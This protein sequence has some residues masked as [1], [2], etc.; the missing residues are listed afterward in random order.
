M[1]ENQ[2]FQNKNKYLDELRHL[3][4]QIPKMKNQDWLINFIHLAR[5][6]YAE[7]LGLEGEFSY[8][9]VEK[10]LERLGFSG[11]KINQIREFNDKLFN[12]QFAPSKEKTSLHSLCGELQ[13]LIEGSTEEYMS[14]NRRDEKNTDKPKKKHPIM[15][16]IHE[17][18]ERKE[19][20]L[21]L[22]IRRLIVKAY[23]Y[24]ENNNIKQAAK[25]YNEIVSLFEKTKESHSK[26][27]KEIK[28]LYEEI[29]T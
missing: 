23:G 2:A 17:L 7:N 24:L 19:Q 5:K 15:K 18:N 14:I 26:M 4:R 28:E 13:D 21:I 29:I 8:K 12:L 6:Y 11:E 16:F 22:K 3:K 9:E 27:K 10:E 1:E 25:C 20:Q